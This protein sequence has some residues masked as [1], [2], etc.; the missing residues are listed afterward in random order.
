[1]KCQ[2]CGVEWFQDRI[3]SVE[4]ELYDSD[5]NK[6]GVLDV[7]VKVMLCWQC[8]ENHHFNVEMMP[9]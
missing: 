9:S 3:Y 6:V 4:A 8:Y 1:M 2:V 5:A 7:T